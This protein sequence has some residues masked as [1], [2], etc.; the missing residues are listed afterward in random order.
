MKAGIRQA[1]SA[2]KDAHQAVREFHASVVQPEMELVLFFCSNDYEIEALEAELNRLFAGIQ[3]VGCTAAGE[4]GPGGYRERGLAGASFSAE[5]CTAV[6]GSIERLQR[7]EIAQ[8]QALGHRLLQELERKAPQENAENSFALLLIDGLSVR[9]EVVARTFQDALGGIPLVGG[10]AGDGLDFGRTYVYA[11]GSFRSDCAAL[12]LVT[13]PLPFTV[14][15]TQH[16]VATDRR[17]VITEADTAQRVVKEINGL[18]AA[19]EYARLLGLEVHDLTPSRFAA[20]PMVVLIDGNNYVRSI[21]KVNSD[22]SLTFYC[23]IEE[24]LVLRVA[25]GVDLVENLEEAFAQIRAE[26]GPPQLMIGCDCILRRMEIVHHRLENRV[27]EIFR[28][29]NAVG[30]STYGEQFHGVHINQTLTG[31]AI[32]AGADEAHRG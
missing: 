32:G 3:V 22:G 7:F 30:F 27:G 18:P 13:T 25:R 24:G 31:I 19:E 14:F 20:C 17:L 1:Y 4:I 16:F 8:G 2:A 11:E 12:T 6:S 23:A 5:V 29:N 26:I 9:E 10:S 21:Q 15:K 28:G